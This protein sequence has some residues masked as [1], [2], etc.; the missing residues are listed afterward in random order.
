MCDCPAPDI[1]DNK[2]MPAKLE[3]IEPT[4]FP[5]ITLPSG[6][7][8]GEFYTK[9]IFEIKV[10]LLPYYYALDNC[11]IFNN[12]ANLFDKKNIYD[13]TYPNMKVGSYSEA[14]KQET[15]KE[16]FFDI[17]DVAEEELKYSIPKELKRLAITSRFRKEYKEQPINE[18]MKQE[19]KK[20]KL[21][22]EQAKEILNNCPH[23]RDSVL[24]KFS[25]EELGIEKEEPVDD[26]PK[27]WED[28]KTI[29]GGYINGHSSMESEDSYP[30]LPE[31]KNIFPTKEDCKAKLA[32]AQLRQIAQHLNN[33]KEDKLEG[34]LHYVDFFSTES[35]KIG[36]DWLCSDIKTCYILFKKEDDLRKS[37]KHHRDLWLDYL[38]VPEHQR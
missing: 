19:T 6:G 15:M 8:V 32:E 7:L 33:C 22:A 4:D 25:D 9:N 3:Q 20:A 18:Q 28:L 35:K 29:E 1:P 14:I 2:N 34:K 12:N 21:T 38:K 31:N 17:A 26:F 37:I 23:L 24:K 27:K 16:V 10:S 11:N 36:Y 30:T 13:F 5:K